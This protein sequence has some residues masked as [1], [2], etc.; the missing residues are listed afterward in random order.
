MSRLRVATLATAALCCAG[1][2]SAPADSAWRSTARTFA[3]AI[4]SS[5]GEAACAVLADSVREELARDS[6]DCATGVLDAG[7]EPPGE[8]RSG[9]RFGTA[10]STA[11]DGDV[12][13][14]GRFPDGWQ[15]T[16]AGCRPVPD[17][18]YDCDV[19]GG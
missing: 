19:S 8:I 2:G 3:S 6:G 14:L 1:C 11:F 15:V 16:A 12:Y 17:G 13:F 18:P 9:E 7:L 10:A 5:D 4:A